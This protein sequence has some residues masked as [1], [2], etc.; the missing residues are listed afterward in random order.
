MYLIAILA[1]IGFLVYDSQDEIE[2]VY[3]LFGAVFFIIIGVLISAAPRKVC[4]TETI[5]YAD[6]V[7]SLTK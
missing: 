5:T 3:S 7:I 2:R 6:W 4:T 1:A